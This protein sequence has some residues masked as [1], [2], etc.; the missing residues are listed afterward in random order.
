MT[1]NPP[2]TAKTAAKDWNA[3]RVQALRQKL[4]ISQEEMARHLGVRQQTISEWETGVYAPRG[5]SS[6]MLGVLAE[7]AE[8]PYR[9]ATHT[10]Q[11]TRTD[12]GDG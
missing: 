11:A 2:P 4:D 1:K 9:A 7:R 3:T 12:Q 6:M 10:E 8:R 5:A